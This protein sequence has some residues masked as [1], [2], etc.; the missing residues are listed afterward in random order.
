M[1]DFLQVRREKRGKLLS[2]LFVHVKQLIF[3]DRGRTWCSW[4]RPKPHFGVHRLHSTRAESQELCTT[5]QYQASITQ[6][7][8]HSPLATPSKAQDPAAENDALQPDHRF[9][10]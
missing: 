2:F 7:E 9:T 6:L 8:L 10:A 1:G 3:N 5:F 4:G